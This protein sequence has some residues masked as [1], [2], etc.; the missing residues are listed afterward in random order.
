M[1]DHGAPDADVAALLA[2][3][4]RDAASRALGMELVEVARGRAVVRM[5]VRA[6]MLQGHG[7]CHGGVLFALCDTAFAFACNGHERVAV[8]SVADITWVAPAVEGDVL[9]ATAV[10]RAAWGRSGLTDVQVVRERDGAL[11]AE[12]RGRSRLAGG[13][14]STR[15]PA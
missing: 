1:G 15:S 13:H 4:E 2:M 11:V 7:T 5:P 8:G 10:E 6:D 14:G 9:R 3:W 12:F